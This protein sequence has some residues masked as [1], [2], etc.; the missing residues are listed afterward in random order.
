MRKIDRA[1]ARLGRVLADAICEGV[2]CIAGIVAVGW[3]MAG[4]V[5][6]GGRRLILFVPVL[7][8]QRE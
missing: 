7:E 8:K 1:V 4:N 2:F 6:S 5:G 3:R